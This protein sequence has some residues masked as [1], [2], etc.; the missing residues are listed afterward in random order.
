MLWYQTT[1]KLGSNNIFFSEREEKEKIF[2][3][4]CFER[5]RNLAKANM[6]HV[7][8]SWNKRKQERDLLVPLH[9]RIFHKKL[10]YRN[11][12]SEEVFWLCYAITSSAVFERFKFLLWIATWSGVWPLESFMLTF[13]WPKSTMFKHSF[14]FVKHVSKLHFIIKW[15]GHHPLTPSYCTNPT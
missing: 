1:F 2:W 9:T 5:R 12:S 13:G 7:V 4:F 15:K 6:D 14:A 11:S 8:S 10:T 3:M